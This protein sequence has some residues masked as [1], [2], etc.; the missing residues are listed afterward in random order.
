MLQ[1]TKPLQSADPTEFIKNPVIGE[2]LGFTADST[3]RESNLE[4]SIIDNLERFMLELGKGF[5]YVGRQ[6]HIH[7]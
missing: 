6:Y 2:F 7:T 4:T 1:L 5:A 3:F